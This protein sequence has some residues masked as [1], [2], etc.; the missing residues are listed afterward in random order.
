MRQEHIP[1]SAMPQGR[2]AQKTAL[3]K[4]KANKHLPNKGLIE[5]EQKKQKHKPKMRDNKLKREHV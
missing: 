3:A 4:Q 2:M 5:T 1:K